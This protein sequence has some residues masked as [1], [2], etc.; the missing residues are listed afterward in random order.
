MKQMIE[1]KR[2]YQRPAM[3]VVELQHQGCILAGSDMSPL[4]YDDNGGDA[5]SGDGSDSGTPD[6]WSDNGG[7]AWK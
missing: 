1:T 3:T 5:W 7:D 6:G 2:E 4:G